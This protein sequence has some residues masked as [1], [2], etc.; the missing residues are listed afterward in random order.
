M[1]VHV[2]IEVDWNIVRS[3]VVDPLA[4]T[5]SRSQAGAVVAYHEDITLEGPNEQGFLDQRLALEKVWKRLAVT[6]PY[7]LCV[8]IGSSL[9]GIVA[10]DFPDL[11]VNQLADRQN[12]DLAW[13]QLD[14]GR[15]AYIRS[16]YL[17]AVMSW[18]DQLNI[19]VDRIELAPEALERVVKSDFT[20]DLAVTSGTGWSVQFADGAVV[21]AKPDLA[22]LVTTGTRVIAPTSCRDLTTVQ[23]VDIPEGLLERIQLKPG[24]LLVVA[25]AALGAAF[26]SGGFTE[27]NVAHRVESFAP[28]KT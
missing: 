19:S 18:F 16:S 11:A 25:G 12:A 8:S 6:E 10:A 27:A 28:V 22:Q 5:P 26:T 9:A 14:S 15:V 20:G 1:V 17:D 4:I 13:R 2:G 24:A 7:K 23:N 21:M 3:C